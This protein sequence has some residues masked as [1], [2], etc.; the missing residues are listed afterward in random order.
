MEVISL[1]NETEIDNEGMTS[2]TNMIEKGQFHQGVKS[3]QNEVE[4]IQNCLN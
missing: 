1:I 3:A 4:F 2:I